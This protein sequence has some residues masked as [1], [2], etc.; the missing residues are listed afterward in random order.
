LTIRILEEPDVPLPGARA[1]ISDREG[2]PAVPAG[3]SGEDGT[4]QIGIPTRDLHLVVEAELHCPVD[5]EVE[6]GETATRTFV[7]PGT[8]SIRGRLVDADGSGVLRPAWVLAYLD[9]RPPPKWQVRDSMSAEIKNPPRPFRLT[10]AEPDGTFEVAGLAVH[11]DYSIVVGGAG[12][13]TE[14][15]V[16]GVACGSE[17]V[18]V[19]VDHSY[20]LK[21]GLQL[22]AGGRVDDAR[23]WAAP[24][25]QWFWDPVSASGLGTDS[26]EAL[27]LGLQIDQTLRRP[28][29][30]VVL[31]FCSDSPEQKVGPIRFEGT[32]MGYSP[33]EVTLWAKP[34]DTDLPSE[35]INLESTVG[36]RGELRI[37]FDGLATEPLG[38][39]TRIQNVGAILMRPTTEGAI[40]FTVDLKQLDAE[41]K[42]L[43]GI[44]YGVYSM[45]FFTQ[46]GYQRYPPAE[47]PLVSIGEFETTI[48][49]DLQDACEAQLLVSTTSDDRYAGEL[50][51]EISQNQSD[52]VQQSVFV[53]FSG[54]P[55]VIGGLLPTVYGFTLYR[56]FMSGQARSVDLADHLDA[57]RRAKVVFVE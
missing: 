56:P 27:L 53:S 4:I 7:L 23:L 9:G 52:G 51:V 32:L 13:V 42:V 11:G 20:G 16:R 1:W 29:A 3:P 8:G 31:L 47:G 50:A 48:H 24:G 46:L 34:F 57:A 25:L 38:W 40:P 30:E 49:F 37:R 15:P 36:E 2:S 39:D 41:E 28:G 14:K 54:P 55:Y 10:R 18:D 45:E 33:I 12:Y 43:R 21:I 35:T 5:G 22:A 44:P 19:Q 17:G 6:R 26:L